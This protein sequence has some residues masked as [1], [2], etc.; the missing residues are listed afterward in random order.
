MHPL[1]WDKRVGTQL[2]I[3]LMN[4]SL[5]TG[6]GICAKEQE[7]IPPLSPETFHTVLPFNNLLTCP[8]C[9]CENKSDL[10]L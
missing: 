8:C 6:A 3:A 4:H 1:R 5:F 7:A 2:K 9:C 10:S